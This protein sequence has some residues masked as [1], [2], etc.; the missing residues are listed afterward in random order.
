M[1]YLVLLVACNGDNSKP[2]P[3]SIPQPEVVID[4]PGGQITPD[5]PVDISNLNIPDVQSA[6]GITPIDISTTLS[7]GATIGSNPLYYK[8][9]IEP[10]TS[11]TVIVRGSGQPVMYLSDQYRFGSCIVGQSSSTASSCVWS[12]NEEGEIFF[13]VTGQAGVESFVEILIPPGVAD[14]P[15]DL[16]DLNSLPFQSQISLGVW[17]DERGIYAQEP[18]TYRIGSLTPGLHYR[19]LVESPDLDSKSWVGDCLELAFNNPRCRLG[20]EDTHPFDPCEQTG[21]GT[22][23]CQHSASPDGELFVAV[24]PVPGA[25]F[26][27]FT[28]DI[29]PVDGVYTGYYEGRADAPIDITN[30]LPY[31]GGYDNT[32]SVSHYLVTGLTPGELYKLSIDRDGDFFDRTEIQIGDGEPGYRRAFGKADASGN[33]AIV[34][35]VDQGTFSVSVKEAPT[36]KGTQNVPVEIDAAEVDTL[37]AEVGTGYSWYR[38]ENLPPD[39]NYRISTTDRDVPSIVVHPNYGLGYPDSFVCGYAAAYCVYKSSAEG[40]IL[41]RIMDNGGQ[42]KFGGEVTLEWKPD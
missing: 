16:Q 20:V 42:Q 26:A 14:S 15:P 38:L 30:Q 22:Y 4:N 9:S 23:A 28:L 13:A 18:H 24:E 39:S 1:H 29:V 37:L 32:F 12:S 36:D 34:L 27:E 25:H 8:L 3:H 6:P 33:A 7:H 35:N 31:T 41:V 10:T 19:V 11:V 40:S 17:Q 2:A 5:A 21:D